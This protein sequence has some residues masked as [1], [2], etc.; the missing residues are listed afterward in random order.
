MSD[1]FAAVLTAAPYDLRLV[2]F[3]GGNTLPVGLAIS[4]ITEVE[5]DSH[6]R[7]WVPRQRP[8]RAGTKVDFVAKVFG[9]WS[10]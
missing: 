9:V 3:E 8:P 2:T 6:F 4:T 10:K 1:E 5:Y 7:S